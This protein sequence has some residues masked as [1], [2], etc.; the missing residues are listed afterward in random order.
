MPEATSTP[1]AVFLSYASQDADAARRIAE[2]LRAAGIEVWFDQNEL[3]GGDAWDQKIRRQIKECA[4]FVPIISANTQSRTEGYFR[5]EWRLAEQRTHLMAKGRPFLLPTVIDET[6]DRDAHVPDAFLEVQWTRLPGGETPAKFVEQVRKLLD[7]KAVAGVANPGAVE[8]TPGSTTPAT[9]KKRSS[10]W[11][12]GAIA[13]IAV[14]VVAAV[15]VG[16]KTETPAAPSVVGTQSSA[17]ATPAP[18]QHDKSIA[19]LPFANMSPDPDN[20]FFCDGMHE[21]VI[22]ALAKISDLRVISRTSVMRYREENSRNLRDIG[23]ELGVNTV[24]EGSVRRV[25]NHLR[26]TAQ[27][28]NA[29]SDEHL[30][31]ETYDRE[32]TD[33]FELQSELAQKIAGSLQVTLSPPEQEALQQAPTKDLVAYDLYLRARTRYHNNANSP[34]LVRQVTAWLEEALERDPGFVLAWADFA[35]F[36]ASFYSDPKADPTP[37]RLTMAENALARAMALAPD[38]NEVLVARGAVDFIA[39]QDSAKA[40]PSLRLAVERQPGNA[41]AWNWLALCQLGLGFWQD[42]LRSC[43]RALQLQPGNFESNVFL[44]QTNLTMRRYQ[45]AW[46]VY[47]RARRVSPQITQLIPGYLV[48]LAAEGDLAGFYSALA[49]Q[50][51]GPEFPEA[52][53]EWEITNAFWHRDFVATVKLA[54]MLPANYEADSLFHGPLQLLHSTALHLLAQPDAAKRVAD[55]WLQRRD[56][57]W[58][59]RVGPITASR[60]EALAQALGGNE[61]AARRLIG[62]ALKLAGQDG[63][64][65][66]L[67]NAQLDYLH[68]IALLGS[69]DETLK[70]LRELYRG[71]FAFGPPNILRQ[72]PLLVELMGDDPR[73]EAV[74]QTAQPL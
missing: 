48:Q 52:D 57:A 58:R 63:G 68:V 28:I 6:L 21:D 20:A 73:F 12:W 43:E 60:Q 59:E 3:V 18:T 32:L 47:Q 4:L 69:R 1:A 39:H 19:V 31:A 38:S 41:D 74:L 34:E 40:L 71:P 29:R 13:A 10:V 51:P 37:E 22:T 11:T 55:A 23:T 54:E 53:R 66:K 2:A 61:V 30:W 67:N 25:G 62:A 7:R 16:R 70:V 44:V 5:L 49:A 24:L 9:T 64:G 26:I 33:M 50:R 36:N 45:E 14:G 65:M 56:A 8:K 27:L 35:K 17:A 46:R 72:D 42:A 15:M